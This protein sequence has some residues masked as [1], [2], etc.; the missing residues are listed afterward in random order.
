MCGMSYMDMMRRSKLGRCQYVR[1]GNPNVHGGAYLLGRHVSVVIDDHYM[2]SCSKMLNCLVF[3]VL[4]VFF[5]I[6]IQ[7]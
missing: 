7:S 4:T 6:I 3:S 2:L 5:A 1:D